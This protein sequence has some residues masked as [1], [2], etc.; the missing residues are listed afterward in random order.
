MKT[1]LQYFWLIVIFGLPSMTAVAQPVT[2]LNKLAITQ[3]VG[4]TPNLACLS[5]SCFGMEVAPGF[6]VWTDFGSGTDGGIIIGKNQTSG[7]QELAP[8]SG[9][10]TPGQLSTAWLFF[11]NYG[12]FFTAPGGNTNV[13]DDTP[14]AGATCIGKTALNVFNV[15]WNGNTIPMGS[16]GG[17]THANCIPDQA[18]GIFIKNYT[19]N[20]TPGGP[21]SIDYTQV[22]PSGQFL[23]VRFSLLMRGT[24]TN[25]DPCFPSSGNINLVAT[26][27]SVAN[28]VPDVNCPG[29]DLYPT[30]CRIVSAPLNGVAT[31]ASNC[32]T[33]TY[34]SNAGFF[35]ID[36]FTYI[37]SNQFSEGPPG[38]VTVA[39]GD[40]HPTPTFTPTVTSSGTPT[41]TPSPLC[42]PNP[43]P[44]PLL[45][46]TTPGQSV[47]WNLGLYGAANCSIVTSPVYGT[48]TM[49]ASCTGTYTPNIGFIGRDILTYEGL[50][51]AGNC[52]A[53]FTSTITIDVCPAGGCAAPSPTPRPCQADHPVTQL[54]SLGKQGTLSITLTGNIVSATNKE[55][56]ICPGTALSYTASS[57]KDVVKCKVKN[58]LTSGSGTLRIRDHL[59]CTDKPLGKDKVQFKVKSGVS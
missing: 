21:W 37:S 27:G 34:I 40:G 5:G 52:P 14:C 28:W 53:N 38:T 26:T 1:V 33:G 36:S 54:S 32:S 59:K 24:F 49:T 39:V 47:S 57:T 25:G 45:L 10:T 3:G 15:A 9:N 58:S 56:K 41:P 20:T 17:C 18:S 44:S 31:V 42:T 16:A 13:F 30:T 29:G 7:G 48:A 43:H 51:T 50:A 35:G 12:T 23:G 4:S 22:V 8:S 46:S 19:I 55:I 2:V 6:V 11:G